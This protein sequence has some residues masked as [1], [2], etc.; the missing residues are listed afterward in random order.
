[1]NT[2]ITGANRG[3]G[4]EF[5]RQCR[6][7]GDT[8][9]AGCRDPQSAGDLN[10]LAGDRLRVVRLDV[11]DGDSVREAA[12]A[13]GGPVGL[14]VNNAGVYGTHRDAPQTVADTSAE[15]FE[16]VYRV[17]VVG[18][19]RVT[20]AFAGRLTAESVVLNVSSG[21]GSI[22]NAGGDWPAAY[23]C[24]KAALNMLSR[25]AAAELSCR[26]VPISPGWVRTDMGGPG[27]DLSPRE[28]VA[29][30]LRA[31]AD[32]DASGRFLRYDGDTVPW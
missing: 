18:P 2:V 26:V 11:A 15:T 25:I 1:M 32:P 5:A 29:G 17:N 6:D 30:M 9:F 3:L 24:S 12:A 23:C 16:D 31:A 20:Q 13:V 14:L 19:L 21:Y 28:S 8:V 22:E 27:A 7:R 4:L 10:A